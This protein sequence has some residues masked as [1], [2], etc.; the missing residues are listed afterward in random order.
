MVTC[1]SELPGSCSG[2]LSTPVTLK[3][4]IQECNQKL[5]DH[6]KEIEQWYTNFDDN[7]NKCKDDL[8]VV[9]ELGKF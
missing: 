4:E 8:K 3:N 2:L 5:A 7:Y 1:L 6:R 9:F